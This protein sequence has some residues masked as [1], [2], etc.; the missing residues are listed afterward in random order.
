MRGQPQDGEA[1]HRHR[2]YGS[3]PEAISL[4]FLKRNS[5]WCDEG[6]VKTIEICNDILGNL[7][8]GQQ[9]RND[10]RHSLIAI[11]NQIRREQERHDTFAGQHA[12]VLRQH[13]ERTGGPVFCVPLSAHWNGHSKSALVSLRVCLWS[14]V[15]CK[16]VSPCLGV[17]VTCADVA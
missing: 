2:R 10:C 15:S 5:E 16:S 11:V 12:R 7:S 17:C 9:P 13:E 8:W 3:R 6:Q 4:G 1:G 14:V